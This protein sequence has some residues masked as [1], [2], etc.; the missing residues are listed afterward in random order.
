LKP[1]N[2][3]FTA[4][5]QVVLTDFGIARLM[6]TTRYTLTGAIVGT[7]A[8]MSPEQAQGERGDIRSDIYSLGVI[9]H[10]LVTGR[11]PFDAD[12]PF[13][14]M[15]KHVTEPL[16]PPRQLKPDL[17]EAVE[18]VIIKALAKEPEARY[19]TAGALA[20]ALAHSCLNLP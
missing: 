8:Y 19:Q 4:A 13:G 7:P 6:D 18:Q 1:A 20:Q 3:M 11:V 14:L 16:S 15:L 12:T 17:P 10:E 2:I 9:L 5:G